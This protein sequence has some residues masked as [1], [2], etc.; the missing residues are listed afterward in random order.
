MDAFYHTGIIEKAGFL[1]TMRIAQVS[2]SR[3]DQWLGVEIIVLMMKTTKA[4]IQRQTIKLA[5]TTGGRQQW[6]FLIAV[7]GPIAVHRITWWRSLD[8]R[9]GSA[10]IA[11]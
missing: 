2:C 7:I 1:A 4:R 10:T 3:V 8:G 5:T 9:I 11:G 6:R